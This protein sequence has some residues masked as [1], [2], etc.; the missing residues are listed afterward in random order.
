MV[1]G[2][3]GI[4]AITWYRNNRDSGDNRNNMVMGIAGITAITF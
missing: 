4:T 2:I 3:A 1:M